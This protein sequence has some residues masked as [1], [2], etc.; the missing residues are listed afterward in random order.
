M[1]L[2]ICIS[3]T[4]MEL[5]TYSIEGTSTRETYNL[6]TGIAVAA[7][8][9]QAL[10]TCQILQNPRIYDRVTTI[11]D[12][13]VALVP[14]EEFSAENASVLYESAITLRHTD[15]VATARLDKWGVV[16]LF[17]VNKDLRFVLGES[18]K[19]VQ[20]LPRIASTLNECG[21]MAYGGFQEKLFA[22]FNGK[23]FDLI[24]FR[25]RRIRFCNS[26]IAEDTQDAVYFIMSVWQQ[27]AMKPTDMLC[28]KGK[29]E[30]PETLHTKLRQFIKNVV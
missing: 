22:V 10:T 14:Q 15:E 12:S 2:T 21:D 13:P 24:A 19:Y 28:V 9:R 7:N 20:F 17:A 1:K 27:L 26:F 29:A 18:F 5:T 3:D 6:N 30:E 4:T 25:K 23:R 11:V 8:M 16:A